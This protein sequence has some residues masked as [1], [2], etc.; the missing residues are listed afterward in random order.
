MAHRTHASGGFLSRSDSLDPFTPLSGRRRSLEFSSY[1]ES[2]RI[3]RLPTLVG[4]FF[5]IGGGYL[6]G[7]I[8][9]FRFSLGP[10]AV[11]FSCRLAG[12]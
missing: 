6:L 8:S 2:C 1:G 10:A 12:R 4:V 3:S 7:S 9:V 11:L 5:V